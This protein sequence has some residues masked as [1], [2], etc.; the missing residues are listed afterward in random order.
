[1]PRYYVYC[2]RCH[3]GAIVGKLSEPDPPV[4]ESESGSESKSV[5]R[6]Q[7]Y[8]YGRPSWGPEHVVQSVEHL[9][10]EA[11]TLWD[12]AIEQQLEHLHQMEA[13]RGPGGGPNFRWDRADSYSDLLFCELE[14]TLKFVVHRAFEEHGPSVRDVIE[15][16]DTAPDEPGEQS[17]LS[18]WTQS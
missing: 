13:V 4:R 7:S 16:K 5:C 12:G 14:K 15:A 2:Q 6:C 3:C 18:E 8:S 1:M 10:G 17:P 11:F 9:P